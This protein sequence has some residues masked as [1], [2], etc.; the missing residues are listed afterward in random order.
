MAA[1]VLV[2]DNYD[3]FVY[4]LVQYLG[5][6]GAAPIVHRNDA[7]SVDAA[8]AIGAD[9]ILVSPGPGRPEDAGISCGLIEAAASAGTPVLGVCLGHQA[10]GHVFGA[11]ISRAP[12]LMHGKTSFIEH[13][14]VGVFAGLPE[15]AR[16]HPLPLA[17][18]GS[19][20]AARRAARSR[21]RPPTARSWASATAPTPSKASSSTRSRSSRWPATTSC[22][23]SWLR[24]PASPER[25]CTRPRHGAANCTNVGQVVVVGFSVVLGG[26]VVVVVG[27]GTALPTTSDTVSPLGSG[28]PG[29][30]AWLITLPSWVELNGTSW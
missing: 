21:P 18:R 9:A 19:R 25:W 14:G 6:L 13:T 12:E 16:G 30:G 29:A 7:L 4:N 10:V 8:M 5:E 3:S 24:R 15:P 26:L 1:R 2:I 23:P 22:A 17:G 20:R 28:V 11:Q 27:G